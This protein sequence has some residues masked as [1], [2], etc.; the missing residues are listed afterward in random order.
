MSKGTKQKVTEAQKRATAKYNAKAY[1]RIELRVIK[2]RKEI[3]SKVAEA[4]GESVNGLI[5]RAID[6]ELER[7]GVELSQ[8]EKDG[9]NIAD[10]I[11]D[12]FD[13]KA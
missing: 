13:N 10:Y 11:L 5:N 4:N 3:I 7:L 1:E 6:R 9:L 2:G 12:V 8:I